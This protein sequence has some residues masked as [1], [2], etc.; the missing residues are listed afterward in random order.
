[1]EADGGIDMLR[2][3]SMRKAKHIPGAFILV[4][5]AFI[6]VAVDDQPKLFNK[7]KEAEQF[8]SKKA[9]KRAEGKEDIL[10]KEEI[11][12]RLSALTAPFVPNT[13]QFDDQVRFQAAIFSGSFYLTGDSLVYSFIEKDEAMEAIG[14]KQR[15]E[16]KEEI[17]TRNSRNKLKV[18]AIKEILLDE[19]SRPVKFIPKGEE[20]VPATVSYFMGNDPSAWK[21]DLAAYSIVSLGEVYPGVE[22]QLKAAGRNVEKA[23]LLKPGASPDSIRLKVEGVKSLSASSEGR[24]ALVTAE[25]QINMSKP[26]AFQE[27]EGIK[28]EVNVEYAICGETEYGFKVSTYDPSITLVIDPAIDTLLASTFL[29]GSGRDSCARMTVDQSG[30]IYVTG[31]TRSPDFPSVTGVHELSDEDVSRAFVAFLNSDL[32]ALQAVAF[33]TGGIPRAIVLSE[34]G[35]I[36]IAGWTASAE[37]PVTPGAYDTSP[38]DPFSAFISR[39]DSSLNILIASTFLGGNFFESV[40]C[41]ALDSYGNIYVAG[42]TG[43]EDFPVSPDAFQTVKNFNQDGFIS[44]L[45]ASLSTLLASTFIGGEG[46]DSVNDISL[47]N[48]LNLYVAGTTESLCFPITPGAFDAER[49]GNEAFVSRLT[50]DL[51]TLLASTYLGGSSSDYGQAIVI[52][53]QGN[54]CLTG[55]T[56][57]TDF[58]ITPSAFKKKRKDPTISEDDGFVSILSGDLSS[59]LASTYLGG[60]MGDNCFDIAIDGSGNIYVAGDTS[61]EDF[62]VTWGSY[63]LSYGGGVVDQFISRLDP[64]LSFL[65]ASTYL[66]GMGTG[67]IVNIILNGSDGIFV[68]GPTSSP[69]FPTTPGA[70]DRTLDGEYDGFISKLGITEE[71]MDMDVTIDTV[72]S[73]LTV[74]VDGVIYTG[75]QVFNWREGTEHT[76][77]VPSP[78]VETP[79]GLKPS[80]AQKLRSRLG[81]V[82]V[83]GGRTPLNQNGEGGTRYVFSTWSDGGEQSHTITVRSSTWQYIANFTRQYTL[84]VSV[85]PP[86]GG[87]VDPS[88]LNWMDEGEVVEVS[89]TANPGYEFSSWS[90][91]IISNSRLITVMI[92][93]PKSLTANFLLRACY[94]PLNISLQRLENNIIFFKEYVNRLAWQPNPQNI[95]QVL[96]YRIYCKPK[97]AGDE[98]YRLLGEVYY[99]TLSY[100]HRGLRRDDLFTYRVTAVNIY[101]LESEYIEISN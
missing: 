53:G 39:L 73:G 29:G 63:D 13:G 61:S 45:D 54:I 6:L 65:Q 72:P 10:L 99:S 27:I 1:M 37:F 69:D 75:P 48:S 3:F 40:Y 30:H 92:D 57:S 87:T 68:I 80:L 19:Q 22:L 21:T 47:D 25:G 33:L 41:M 34:A 15:N 31:T 100:D 50:G 18:I 59:L 2:H 62:P 7:G 28:K 36:F 93:A 20:Q 84:I 44:K 90:G 32:S 71:L 89:A 67:G 52:D 43:S 46:H 56:L 79:V 17:K 82:P 11:I 51:R 76:I 74:M 58:P 78:Q 5:L 85:N 86:E 83:T 4:L 23:F 66:G 35:D 101:G 64:T 98:N 38:N 70:L 26:V 96:K 42:G 55:Y 60:S 97:G 14:E 91:D 81:K 77:S 95:I 49:I 88:G 24:L 8:L 9:I 16:L 12:S 94:P